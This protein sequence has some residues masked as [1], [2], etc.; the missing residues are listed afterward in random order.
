[1][2]IEKIIS[3]AVIQSL[4]G[5]SRMK[6][7]SEKSLGNEL[8]KNRNIYDQYVG[9]YVICRTRNEG[10]NAGKV[11]ACDPTGVILEDARRLW[12]YKPADDDFSWYEGVAN[13]G[14]SSESKLSVPAKKLIVEDYSLTICTEQAE[15][16][17]RD[18]KSYI[19]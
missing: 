11:V 18:A 10:V 6:I 14:V 4:R 16:S 12:Y 8:E 17:I 15:K 2:D 1:M 9:K 19:A 7:E 13:C 5:E 3:N